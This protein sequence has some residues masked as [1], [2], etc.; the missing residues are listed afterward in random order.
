MILSSL[1]VRKSVLW[2]TG[3]IAAAAM[4]ACGG[5]GAD[6]AVNVV[7]AAT[8]VAITAAN[9]ATATAVVGALADKPIAFSAGVPA[10]STTAATTVTLSQATSTTADAQFSIASDGKT[11]KG[12]FKI[13]SCIFVITTSDFVAPSPLA[14]GRTVTVDPCSLTVQTAGKAA[15]GSTTT[16]NVNVVLGNTQ[17]ESVAIPVAVTST[18]AIQ[19]SGATV[20]TVRPVPVTG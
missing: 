3:A 6:D 20:A 1:V 15:D 5:G 19:I 8:P 4:V 16:T 11:A 17:A 18:G 7:A 9:K 13:G 12:D 2:A 10:F 14:V